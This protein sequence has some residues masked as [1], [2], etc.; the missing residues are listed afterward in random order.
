MVSK[1]MEGDDRD[2]Y[3]G[4]SQT[5]ILLRNTKKNLG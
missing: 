3:E 4:A 1:N 2:M 5:G